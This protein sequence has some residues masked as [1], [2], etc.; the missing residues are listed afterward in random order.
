MPWL[1][2]RRPRNIFSRFSISRVSNFGVHG[3]QQLKS[4]SLH[5]SCKWWWWWSLHREFKVQ[6]VVV[7]TSFISHLQ[8]HTLHRVEEAWLSRGGAL[9]LLFFLLR[10]PFLSIFFLKFVGGAWG[11]SMG[12]PAV[13]GAWA[14]PDPPLD[15]PLLHL[16]PKHHPC[17]HPKEANLCI[18][19]KRQ[20]SHFSPPN[21]IA[22]V[23]VV[24]VLS[25][26]PI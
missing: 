18:G 12:F 4:S 10:P 21:F 23:K 1:V 6:E 16:Q 26:W 7:I 15:P 3:T 13:G 24:H 25:N 9:L 2:S 20:N 17:W 19:F 22:R 14:P 11:G 5:I 8:I